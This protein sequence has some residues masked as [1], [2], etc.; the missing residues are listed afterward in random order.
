MPVVR[1][2]SVAELSALV[3]SA[4]ATGTPLFPVG[5]RTQLSLGR[6]PSRAGT[7][8]DLTALDQ[9][10]D[11]PARDMTVTVQAGIR[12][13][14]LRQLLHREGQR[15]PID[16]P[17][18][19]QAT[20]GG[21]LATNASG[22]R[23]FGLGTLRDYV[24]GISFLS[25]EGKEVRGGGRVVK[26]VAGYDLCKLLI[27]S[28]GTLGIVTQVTLKVKPLPESSKLLSLSLPLESVEATLEAIHH[29][30]TRP[31]AVELLNSAAA[32]AVGVPYHEGQAVVVVGYEDNAK[33]VDWQLA[34]L[35]GEL[36]ESV[37][38]ACVPHTGPDAERL[39]ANLENLAL[40]PDA[41][42]SFKA[43]VLPSRTAEYFVALQRRQ[44]SGWLLRAHAG[45]GIVVGHWVD[46]SANVT[47]AVDWVQHA[48]ALATSPVQAQ[49]N[50]IVTHCPTDWK[51]R[52]PIWGRPTSDREMMRTI[53]DRL[54]PQ[55]LFNPG[56][57]VEGF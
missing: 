32:Q 22:A 39:W 38:S 19:E 44:P 56:R 1:P 41:K 14:T 52:L 49:G 23:R 28:L 51:A 4:Q 12:I 3:C 46:A 40:R 16:V 57:F 15:L 54:D 33:A 18:P 29:S 30:K 6:V 20:L 42:L 26:N 25:D 17:S 34:Q 9:V 55:R 53:K 11:Y 37:R 2:A 8:V 48:L 7:V 21:C 24:I 13:A 43:N 47:D 5:G 10:I 31:V 50:L 36:P 35:P 45:N 27:A